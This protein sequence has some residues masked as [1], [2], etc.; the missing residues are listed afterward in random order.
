MRTLP[1][2]CLKLS[3]V[4]VQGGGIDLNESSGVSGY[5]VIGDSRVFQEHVFHN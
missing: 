3:N 4:L 2:I 5:Y 1:N